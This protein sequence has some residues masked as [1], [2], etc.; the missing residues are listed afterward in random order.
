[1]SSSNCTNSFYD[2]IA[3]DYHW[4]YRDWDAQLEREGLSLRRLFRDRTITTVLDASCGPG[5][6]AIALARLGFAVTA[7]DPSGGILERARQ[8]A[9]A[10]SLADRIVFVQADFQSLHAAVRGPFDA[11]ITK[12][13]SLAHLLSDDQI[14]EALLN[15]HELLRP[16]GTLLIGMRDFEPLLEDRPRFWP[17]QIHDLPG[18]QL[19]TFDVWNWDDGPPITVTVDNFIVRG[20]GEQY[21]TSCRP[22]V[23]RALTASEV[24][25]LLAD[26]GFEDIQT[27]HDR[28]EVILTATRPG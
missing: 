13:G 15:F 7:A 11:V 17:G 8:N 2:A 24:T 10:H 5:T 18:E 3:D 1:M 9:A 14:E 25:A 26:I 20:R 6:Q 21:Q 19:I 12:G 27:Q 28:W 16:G 22:V 4:L 23:Y